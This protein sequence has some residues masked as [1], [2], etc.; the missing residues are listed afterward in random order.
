MNAASGAYEDRVLQGWEEIYKRGQLTLWVLLAL[1]DGAKA[2]G[3]IRHWLREITD[4]TVTVEERSLYRVL[5]RFDK[6]ELVSF[7]AQSSTKGPDQKLYA[8]TPLGKRILARFIDRNI[9]LFTKPAVRR[10]LA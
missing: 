10:L 1:R 5:Q 9:R 3:E 8:L 7:T 4:D 2:M 6:A